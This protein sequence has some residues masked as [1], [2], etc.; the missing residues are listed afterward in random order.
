MT[1]DWTYKGSIYVPPEN[2][3]SDDYYGFVYLI[4][5]L[6]SDMKYI[7][8]KLF[9]NRKTLG[10]TK[11]RKRRKHSL[12]ESNW[13]EYWGS[14]KTL[15]EEIDKSG[16]PAYSREILHLCKKRGHVKY[17]EA[18]EQFDRNVLLRDDYHNGI[19]QIRVGANSLRGLT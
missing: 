12:V 8:A 17:L 7:G 15:T 3:S 13:R 19:I 1:T 16:Q 4:T 2:F 14:S 6:E 10:V 11:K 5:N 9:W 18:Q